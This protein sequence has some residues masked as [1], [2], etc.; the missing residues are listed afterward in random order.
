[1]SLVSACIFSSTFNPSLALNLMS[2]K[3][4]YFHICNVFRSK[5][6]FSDAVMPIVQRRI[7]GPMWLHFLIGVSFLVL[8]IGIVFS[9]YSFIFTKICFI[10][11]V[12]GFSS[13]WILRRCKSLT[14]ELLDYKIKHPKQFIIFPFMTW[15]HHIRSY[16]LKMLSVMNLEI[17][18]LLLRNDG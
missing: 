3:P 15:A 14:N 1:M 4:T 12:H 10:A 17:S 6:L 18:F 11:I 9:F 13:Y 16:F 5:F 2:M 8:F 7:K